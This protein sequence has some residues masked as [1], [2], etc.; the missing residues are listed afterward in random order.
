M[1]GAEGI[2]ILS[3]RLIEQTEFA[4][5][6]DIIE[7]CQKVLPFIK[8][9]VLLD[10]IVYMRKPEAMEK[11]KE[12]VCSEGQDGSLMSTARAIVT[13]SYRH[14]V[15]QRLNYVKLWDFVMEDYQRTASGTI[16]NSQ[17]HLVVSNTD[18]EK[19]QG[20]GGGRIGGG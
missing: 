11:T 16:S 6:V 18:S 17:V 2:I 10:L 4:Q 14:A 7:E 13:L 9:R 12:L 5:L 19:N 8:C 15:W 3:T 1:A 20:S